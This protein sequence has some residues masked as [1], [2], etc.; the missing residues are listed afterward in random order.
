MTRSVDDLI[1]TSLLSEDAKEKLDNS[2]VGL[3]T[4]KRSNLLIRIQQ[5]AT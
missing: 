5:K 4:P 2:E 1:T 3:K